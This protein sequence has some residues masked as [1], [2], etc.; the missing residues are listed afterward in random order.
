[1]VPGSE[2]S[3]TTL[4][5]PVEV[6]NLPA[7]YALDSVTPAIVKVTV[8]GVRRRLFVLQPSDVTVSVDALLAQLGRRTFDLTPDSVRTPR[9]VTVMAVE[10]GHVVLGLREPEPD[11][12]PAKG[13]R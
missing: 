1:M 3:E 5:A 7:G 2:L 11:G 4:S 13:E 12:G 10:P 9:G 6:G 8:S